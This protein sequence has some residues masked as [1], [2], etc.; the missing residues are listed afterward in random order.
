ML[1]SSLEQHLQQVVLLDQAL[2]L[3]GRHDLI[4][5]INLGQHFG[6]VVVVA[7]PIRP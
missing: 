1:G 5:L 2:L 4:V 7:S 6:V 3:G